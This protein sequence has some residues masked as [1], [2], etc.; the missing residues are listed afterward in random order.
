[1]PVQAGVEALDAR[2]L[3][4]GDVGEVGLVGAFVSSLSR[5]MEW[6]RMRGE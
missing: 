2:I 1:M 6:G 3:L 5:L 4:E